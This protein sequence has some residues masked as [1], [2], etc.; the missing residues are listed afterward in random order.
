[1]MKRN[2]AAA[3]AGMLAI[4]PVIAG[5]G[6]HS[7][8]PPL[9]ASQDAPRASTNAGSSGGWTLRFKNFKGYS[10]A[11]GKRRAARR[12]NQLRAKGQHRKAVR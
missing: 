4:G 5:A 10:C 6:S 7:F 8:A 1:M 11:E 3:V 9:D 2:L 12:R